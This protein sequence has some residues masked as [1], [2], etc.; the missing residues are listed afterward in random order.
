MKRK[1]TLLSI[2]PGATRPSN[3]ILTQNKPLPRVTFSAPLPASNVL[4]GDFAGQ[5]EDE[6]SDD[7]IDITAADMLASHALNIAS[8]T[9]PT[10]TEPNLAGEPIWSASFKVKTRFGGVLKYNESK[11]AMLAAGSEVEGHVYLIRCY[12]QVDDN[13]KITLQAPGSGGRARFWGIE[14]K[15]DNNFALRLMPEEYLFTAQFFKRTERFAL[16]HHGLKYLSAK[17]S[18]ALTASVKSPGANEKFEFVLQSPHDAQPQ[19]PAHARVVQA[20]A[21]T[22]P[23]AQVTSSVA[24]QPAHEKRGYVPMPDHMGLVPP[25]TNPSELLTNMSRLMNEANTQF[26]EE[27][28]ALPNQNGVKL[29][30]VFL[31][32]PEVDGCSTLLQPKLVTF[33]RTSTKIEREYAQQQ[34][35]SHS[36][37]AATFKRVPLKQQTSRIEYPA[38]DFQCNDSDVVDEGDD[39]TIECC[40]LEMYD[41]V[42]TVGK[43]LQ[44]LKYLDEAKITEIS[45]NVSRAS[46]ESQ[47][48]GCAWKPWHFEMFERFARVE[49]ENQAFQKSARKLSCYTGFEDD[50]PTTT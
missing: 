8:D 17:K 18:G 37:L 10:N 7:E 15:G 46:E 36:Y 49:L 41:L 13:F 9:G 34:A 42:R 20:P 6:A 21:P 35:A 19:G 33:L 23:L 2:K 26:E 31:R 38:Q 1:R 32:R 28:T 12:E 5:K 47:F 11:R 16:R 25:G 27:I 30:P 4:S 14:Q 40:D 43:R 22:R 48:G 24:P 3:H 29:R 50:C 45:P 39:D 44:V